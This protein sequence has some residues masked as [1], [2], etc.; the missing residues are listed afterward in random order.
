MNNKMHGQAAMEY[1][2]T[3]GWALLVIVIVIGILLVLN[4]FQA[5]QGCRF[6]QLSFTCTNPI[7]QAANGR[8]YMSVTNG[9]NNAIQ[10]LN[11]TCVAGTT[12]TAPSFSTGVFS[13]SGTIQPQT[14][15]DLSSG[16]NYTICRKSNT[17][18]GTYTGAAGNSF[19]GKVYVYYRYIEDPTGV[20]YPARVAIATVTTKLV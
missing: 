18:S 11:V 2:M 8:I 3:Y 4:P 16:T 14:A 20:G 17:D 5:P 9:N 13:N 1:L 12:P 6:E 10:V 7:V 15:F 19:S